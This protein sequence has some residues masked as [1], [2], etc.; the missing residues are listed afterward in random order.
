MSGS[1]V[2]WRDMS[3][4]DVEGEI[5]VRLQDVVDNLRVD[6]ATLVEDPSPVVQV[7]AVALA[8]LADDLALG[9]IAHH[10]TDPSAL[11]ETA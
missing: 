4:V 2:A 8:G 1:D 6:A 5:Y 3:V 11:E 9:L 7:A 10:L